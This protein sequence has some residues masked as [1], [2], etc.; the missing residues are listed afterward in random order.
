MASLPIDD[1]IAERLFGDEVRAGPNQRN[2]FTL[3]GP[4]TRFI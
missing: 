3:F 2:R 1:D 4:G